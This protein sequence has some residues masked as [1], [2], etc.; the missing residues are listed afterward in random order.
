MKRTPFGAIRLLEDRFLMIFS[1]YAVS[2]LLCFFLSWM[3]RGANANTE[4]V[5][6]TLPLLAVYLPVLFFLRSEE[7]RDAPLGLKR[8]EKAFWP[9]EILFI[10]C[11][12]ALGTGGAL[13]FGKLSL[14][15]CFY[16]MALPDTFSFLS[17]FIK[18][19][20]TNLFW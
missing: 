3:R 1:V 6:F 13:L 18:S 5:L 2:F 17:F 8:I 14:P 9:E 20:R 12:F 10:V 11:A 16:G 15:L 19:Q 7:G 4:A